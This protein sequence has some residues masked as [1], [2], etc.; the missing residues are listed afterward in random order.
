MN[1]VLMGLARITLVGI[2]FAIPLSIGMSRIMRRPM[3]EISTFE[4][5]TFLGCVADSAAMV[6]IAAALS[7]RRA[8]S[9]A[10]SEALRIE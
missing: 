3:S 4:S 6:K 8:T 7:T 10:P 9:F 1:V 5:L 2:A